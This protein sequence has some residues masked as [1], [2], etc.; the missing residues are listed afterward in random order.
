MLR[1]KIS[2]N[3]K[4]DGF[5]K[6]KKI[7]KWRNIKNAKKYVISRKKTGIKFF[8]NKYLFLLYK[9]YSNG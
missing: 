2:G 8:Y 5:K 6:V 7:Q 3:G 1:G 9:I 4:K